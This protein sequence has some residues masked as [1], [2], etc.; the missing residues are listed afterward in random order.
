MVLSLLW[1]VTLTAPL[2]ALMLSAG[3]TALPR[4]VSETGFVATAP[5]ATAAAVPPDVAGQYWKRDQSREIKFGPAGIVS[6]IERA[7]PP[8]EELTRG[9]RVA[10][11]EFSVEFV[12]VQFQNPFGHPTMIKSSPA[13]PAPTLPV[14][15]GMELSGV[16]TT[17]TPMSTADQIQTS[18]ALRDVFER[19][20]AGERTDHRAPDRP[21]PLAQATRS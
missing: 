17:L 13:E 6:I 3:C 8:D 10:I 1:F 14:Q 15:P 20:I 11:T 21:S 12:D 9:R 16:G 19:D 2:I 18:Q 7:G 5:N 4:A